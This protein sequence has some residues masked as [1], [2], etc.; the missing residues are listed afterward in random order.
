MLV[1]RLSMLWWDGG[2]SMR[3]W[4]LCIF[5]NFINIERHAFSFFKIKIAN[6]F[7]ILL[8]SDFS[9]IGNYMTFNSLFPQ[10]LIWM[11]IQTLNRGVN[12]EFSCLVISG[13]LES[14]ATD[15]C[16][17]KM[18]LYRKALQNWVVYRLTGVGGR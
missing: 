7:C 11:A 16:L 6:L 18:N 5:F 3:W 12:V 2:G 8:R 13:S 1:F 9:R 17:R 4:E 14:W 10:K 15:P